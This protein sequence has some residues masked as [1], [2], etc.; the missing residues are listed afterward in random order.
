M[1]LFVAPVFFL[2]GGVSSAF[3]LLRFLTSEHELSLSA[4]ALL[5]FRVSAFCRCLLIVFSVSLL[6]LCF[7]A[8]LLFC[9]SASQR[10]KDWW[11]LE[12]HPKFIRF[13]HILRLDC[14]QGFPT[15]WAM[16]CNLQ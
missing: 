8:S 11:Y 9:F 14:M 13:P 4:S 3:V 12:A 6:L 15:M 7:S 2:L 10:T 5:L 16:H 1:S